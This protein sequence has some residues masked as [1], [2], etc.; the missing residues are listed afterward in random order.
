MSL[1]REHIEEA[2]GYCKLIFPA[3]KTFTALDFCF[4]FV[5]FWTAVM[6]DHTIDDFV[7]D[8]AGIVIG[9]MFFAFSFANAIGFTTEHVA[10]GKG[11]G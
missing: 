10:S 9:E 5:L 2:T 8:F 7:V 11:A 3:R 4:Y 6:R 1:N